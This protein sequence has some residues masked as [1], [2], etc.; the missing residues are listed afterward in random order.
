MSN[1]NI[2]HQS[3]ESPF[4]PPF[5]LLNGE[6]LVDLETSKSLLFSHFGNV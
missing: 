3:Q 2:D 6:F 5:K 1:N 4:E